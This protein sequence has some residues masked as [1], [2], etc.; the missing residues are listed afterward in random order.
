MHICA[1]NICIWIRTLVIESL[2][3]IT[4]YHQGR[5]P[6]PDDGAIL[7][8]IR[9]HSLR[10][11]GT[12][13]GTNYGPDAEWE[14]INVNIRERAQEQPVESILSRIVQSTARAATEALRTTTTTTAA[15]IN[16]ADL[17]STS[18]TGYNRFA[19]ASSSSTTPSTTSDS[20]STT[21][22]TTM[23]RK[24][25]KFIS[26]TTSNPQ[27]ATELLASSISNDDELST[28]K[29]FSSFVSSTANTVTQ[30]TTTP[31]SIF[32]NL[33]AGME[34]AYQYSGLSHN[35][36]YSS[37]QDRSFESLDA[38]FPAALT[39]TVSSSANTNTSCGRINIMG[40]I[41]QDSAPY[42]YPF[43]IEYSL[44]G[45]VV[46][47]VMWKHIGRYPKY[48]EED[49]EHRLEVMLSRRAVAMAQA[50]SGRVDCVG[51][52]KGLFFGLLLLVGSLICLILF[53]VLVRHNQFSLLAI[54]LADVSHCA[55]MAFAVFAIFIGFIRFV[56]RCHFLIPF[57]RYLIFTLF[58]FVYR[59]QTLKF[60]CEEQ[61]NL[62]DILL[63]ISAFGL[64]IY[65]VFSVIAGSLNAFESEPNLLVMI[66]GILAV[67]QVVFQLL[68]IADVSRRRVHLPEHDRSKPGRQIVTFLLIC[69]IAM[70]AIYTFEAQ[71][72]FANPV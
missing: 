61:S 5:A 55:L 45:A 40:T 24:L 59:V 64:F 43:I 71:K 19:A 47:Y 68:F 28:A 38:L 16:N 8:T 67:S 37:E 42:L 30:S 33:F 25:K 21:D 15:S 49:L 20:A 27:A 62:N 6:N 17:T 46:I 9:T 66:T 26:S 41:V 51:A 36:T 54:Y 1:T 29:P 18:T 65:S 35:D 57:F 69:N 52:S 58:F 11:A 2:K 53:F 44:I 7:E 56:V 72:V 34:N 60:R 23:M 4:L 3:E 13:M 32:N 48:T 22:A 70:F 63:R 39:G 14:P 10:H 50:H 31:E 12:V